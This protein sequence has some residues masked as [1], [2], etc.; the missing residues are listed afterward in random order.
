VGHYTYRDV[1]KSPG[2]TR[3][4]HCDTPVT[5]V[6]SLLQRLWWWWWWWSWWSSSS[7]SCWWG[8][9]TSLNC[10]H[11]R[12][13]CLSPRWYMSMD[14]HDGMMMSTEENWFVHQSF[15]AI[16]PAESSGSKQEV[17]A[18]RMRNWSCEVYLLICKWYFT[19]CKILRHGVF[20]FTSPPKERAGFE[21]SNL[22]SNDNH[23]NHYT[24][25]A[26]V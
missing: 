14:N 7:S 15:L 2:K 9:A 18:K 3:R 11:Q 26:T 25:E 12:A 22:V 8:E 19:I 21:P 24:S 10:G 20:S 13:Y 17:W 1:T 4:S 6:A 23:V 5:S 16:L